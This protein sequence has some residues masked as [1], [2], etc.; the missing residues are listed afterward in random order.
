MHH[1]SPTAMRYSIIKLKYLITIIPVALTLFLINSCATE[2][3]TSDTSSIFKGLASSGVDIL[4]D[5]IGNPVVTGFGYGDVSTDSGSSEADIFL[6]RHSVASGATLSF[7]QEDSTGDEDFA[8]A[9][10]E[11]GGNFYVAGHTYGDLSSDAG[12]GGTDIFLMQFNSAGVKQ[13]T[14]Q[15]GTSENDFCWDIT[16]VGGN[17]FLVGNTEGVF[18]GVSGKT[19]DQG[20]DII[21]VKLDSSGNQLGVVQI[22][23]D[24]AINSN[25]YSQSYGVT[26]GVDTGNNIII[27]GITN[28]TLGASKIGGNDIVLAKY[29]SATLSPVAPFNIKQLGTT[30]DDSITNLIT[31]GTDIYFTGFTYG[32][33][34]TGYY[35]ST[36][37]YSEDHSYTEVFLY[38]YD[39]NGD[40]VWVRQNG[41]ATYDRGYALALDGSGNVLV[42][43]NTNG[44]L[45][46][47][48]AGSYD[49]FILSYTTG[50]SLNWTFQYGSDVYDT[51]HGIAYDTVN[52]NLFV[53]GKTYGELNSQ[54]NS[55]SSFSAFITQYDTTPDTHDWTVVF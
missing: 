24:T 47:T 2:D 9:V 49:F 50:G 22:G 6:S 53:T 16:T 40:Q 33:P 14:R 38:K 7:A 31:S 21:L 55:S 12:F 27:G 10:V 1:N 19:N 37:D 32:T 36:A 15:Y 20:N 54:S 5:G 30:Y 4:V 29:D 25:T 11:L 48:N 26:V 13:W 46:G 44:D 45:N 28:D 52:D 43:G 35:D 23:E 8:Q 41:T 17:L 3:N 39:S 42:A 51:V 18:P 34:Q